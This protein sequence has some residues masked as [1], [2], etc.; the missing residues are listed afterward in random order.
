MLNED[1]FASYEPGPGDLATAR[2]WELHDAT[3]EDSATS[4]STERSY[5]FFLTCSLTFGDF[6]ANFKGLVLGC[7]ETN[8][9]K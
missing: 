3:R 2:L 9:C 4:A 7:I 1:A 8:L 6:L 5:M